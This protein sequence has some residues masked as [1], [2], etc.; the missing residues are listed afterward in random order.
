LAPASDTLARRGRLGAD[1]SE[2]GGAFSRSPRPEPTDGL[3]R[4][5]SRSH[6]IYSDLDIWFGRE[7]VYRRRARRSAGR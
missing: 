5:A 4:C 3:T 1:K 2:N 7:G 6:A